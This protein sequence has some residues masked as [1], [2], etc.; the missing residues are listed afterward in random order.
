MKIQAIASSIAVAHAQ[1]SPSD[2]STSSSGPPG[3]D[4]S[5]LGA[6][7]GC[8]VSGT[9]EAVSYT[10][11]SFTSGGGFSG[12]APMPRQVFKGLERAFWLK[13]FL[14]SDRRAKEG[15]GVTY[16]CRVECIIG[17]I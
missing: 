13:V 4:A 3:C 7:T 6:G 9:Q 17:L 5:V 1:V 16:V 11:S 15:G 2:Q 12:I 10:E 14:E 8:L